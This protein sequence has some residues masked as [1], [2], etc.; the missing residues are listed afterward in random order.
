MRQLT[1]AERVMGGVLVLLCAVLVMQRLTAAA[2]IYAQVAGIV[3]IAGLAGLA[4][5]ALG[6]SIARPV[7]EVIDTIDAIA[8]AE[9]NSATQPLP[10]RGEIAQL[11]AATERLAEIL[12]ERQRRELVHDDLDR[13]W[14]AAR[15]QNLSN[16]ADHVEHATEVGIQPIVSG[17]A[18]LKFKAEEMLTALD[19]VRSA[20]DETAGAAEG[21]RAMNQAAGQLSDQVMQAIDDISAQVA[22]GSGLGREAVA[23]ANASRTTIDALAK[24]ADQIGDIV[25]VI[26][27]IAAQTN[28]LA[29]NATIEA[30]R[31]GEAGR[32]FSVVAGEVKTLATRTAASTQR[33][34]EKVSEIQST[35]REA[36]NALAGITEAIDQLSDVTQ[37]VS[38]AVEQQRAA[39][40][41][42]S[43]SAR[44]SSAAVSD[45]AGRMAGIASMIERS[46]AT[47]QDVSGVAADMQTTSLNLCGEIPEIVRKA[48]TADLREHPRYEVRLTALLDYNG[49][50][51]EIEVQDVSEG[52]ARIAATRSLSVGAKIAVTFPGMKP[53][54]GMVMRDGGD[55]CGVCFAPSRLR[56]EE[57]RDLVTSKAKAA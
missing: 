5:R 50:T 36:V 12:G 14:Q 35:T 24:A 22:R 19:T 56:A 13:T 10:V 47:A 2:G 45:V 4:V 40:A 44:E 26:N 28:L 43:S 46:R 7:A 48:V 39:T 33:I 16:L 15:R 11:Q 57:L 18:T 27:Q 6:R 51:T 21:S 31:A 34:G 55:N 17:A 32:G 30:A 53:I 23:R 41:D 42:F 3:A 1:I 25:T 8:Y 52:G 38:A 20:F 29:L 9:M 49:A 54:S 37:S